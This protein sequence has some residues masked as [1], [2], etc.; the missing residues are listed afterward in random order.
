MH[1]GSA[2]TLSFL[3]LILIHI[4]GFYLQPIFDLLPSE[5]SLPPVVP[6]SLFLR[7][8]SGPENVF[9]FTLRR[10]AVILLQS[11]SEAETAAAALLHFHPSHPSCH[12]PDKRSTLDC[13]NGRKES[14]LL[15]SSLFGGAAASR[16]AAVWDGGGG[17]AETRHYYATLFRGSMPTH[18]LFPFCTQG[19]P[20][21]FPFGAK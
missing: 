18:S 16:Y 21:L 10:F 8:P 7:L 6:P 5:L 14:P 11:K 19:V 4:P 13:N 9:F 17:V 1:M 2:P 12:I 15:P 20:F 3:C